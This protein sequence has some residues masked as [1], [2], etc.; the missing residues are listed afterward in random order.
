MATAIEP[1]SFLERNLRMTIT[2]MKVAVAAALAGLLLVGAA[3]CSGSSTSAS[4]NDT[5]NN[6][7]AQ[8]DQQLAFVQPLPNFPF[9]QIRQN[10]IEIEAIQALG[11]SSTTFLFVPGIP[12]PI[13]ECPSQGVPVPASDELSNPVVAQWNDDGKGVAGVGIG[14]QDP[15]GVFQG[16]T[17]GTNGLCLDK[18]GSTYDAYNEAYDVTIT[19]DAYWDNTSGTIVVTGAPVMPVCTVVQTSP[20]AAYE[21]CTAPPASVH[22]TKPTIEHIAPPTVSPTKH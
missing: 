17:T 10:L 13:L 6:L 1:A 22:Q 15:V 20:T 12:H 11:I 16:P 19:A 8:D 14:Q 7:Q 2:R 9:S 5:T 18:T 3:A 21:K 4:G